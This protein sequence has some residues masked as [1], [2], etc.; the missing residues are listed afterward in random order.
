MNLYN[1]LKG[2]IGRALFRY[3]MVKNGDSVIIALSGGEDSLVLA[4]FLSDW[5]K[6][7]RIECKLIGVHLD[8]GFP[9]NEREYH[10]GVKWLEEFCKSLE[11]DFYFLKTDCGIQAMEVYEK[12]ITAPCFVCSWHRRKYLFRLC[13]EKGANKLTL[14]HHLDDAIV[15]FFMNMFYHGELSTILPVQ[16]M[17]KGKL[18]IIRPLILVEKDLISRFVKKMGWN[19][20]ENPCPFSQ[21]T[22]RKEVERILNTCIYPLNPKIKR[23]IA[24][25][26]FNPNFEYL[27]IRK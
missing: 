5:R 10:E 4:Y 6:K 25:A 7:M 8:M 2:L 24:T 1:K 23:S 14:G 11:V 19:L 27:P 20:L 9:K 12:D 16:E 15:T 18:Y 21:E 26:I 17:F 22:K 3:E 13:Q